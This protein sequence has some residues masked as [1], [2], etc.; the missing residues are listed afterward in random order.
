MH[1]INESH[2]TQDSFKPATHPIAAHY[3]IGEQEDKNLAAIVELLTH[4][5]VDTP[6]QIAELRGIEHPEK[7]R[8]NAQYMLSVL[9]DYIDSSTEKLDVGN[10]ATA[11]AVE[12]IDN[13]DEQAMLQAGI[14]TRYIW[15]D[16]V[17]ATMING[18]PPVEIETMGPYMAAH[19]LEDGSID[20]DVKRLPKDE[21]TGIVMGSIFRQLARGVSKTRIVSLLD[22]FN[23]FAT[24]HDFSEGQRNSYITAMTEVYMQAGV[25]LP[26]DN[27]GKDFLMLRE[28]D[29]L[30]KYPG[31]LE[32][33]KE[34]DKG[35][36]VRDESGSLRFMPTDDFVQLLALE[37]KSRR[38]EFRKYG[39]L[40]EQNGRPTC[41]ALDAASFE[42]PINKQFLHLIMLDHSMEAQQDK[43]YALLRAT[44]VVRQERYHNVFFDSDSTSP[45]LVVYGIAKTL[46]K[47]LEQFVSKLDAFTHWDGFDPYE[48]VWR[49]YG[50]EILPEDAAI[51]TK[52]QKRLAERGV[53]P[54]SLER[55]A[56]VGAGP[57]FYPAMLVAPFVTEDAAIEMIE[58]SASNRAYTER[59]KND[60]HAESHHNVW[61][62]F[63]D[64]MVENGGKL[65]EGV[66]DR[67]RSKVGVKAGSIFDLEK[68]VYDYISSYFCAESIT[69]SKK[70]FREAIQSMGS[71]LKENGILVV[72]HMMGTEDGYHAGEDT[73]FPEM[74]LTIDELEEAYRDAELDFEVFTVGDD[75]PLDK[76]A[77]AGYAGMAVVI[78]HKRVK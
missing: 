1:M 50:R 73:H 27:P 32:R 65:Y 9:R 12:A 60:Q 21:Q 19:I 22:D 2:E 76:K 28:S 56:D 31:L 72:A 54:G 6:E 16:D 40:L 4:P 20:V 24:E 26:E 58:F 18:K 67:A 70:E 57:N 71:A 66:V 77:R 23:N 48:Y 61:D 7:K 68:G 33:L 52:V 45:D 35:K 34:S 69:E 13:G 38:A 74:N 53:R 39:I 37:S 17:V 78:A 49:N 43:T 59:T 51:I 15:F 25:I 64:L 41:Q 3:E 46:E 5:V 75:V 8:E 42:N 47:H 10:E 63:Q 44:D 29:Q 55:V 14:D 30:V 11:R 36:I 62:K